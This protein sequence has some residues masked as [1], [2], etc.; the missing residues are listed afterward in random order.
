MGGGRAALPRARKIRLRLQLQL[1]PK[2]IVRQVWRRFRDRDMTDMFQLDF[3]S[4]K[5]IYEQVTDRLKERIFL[6]MIR[7]DE[8]L[9][10]I[11]ELSKQLTVNPNTVQKAFRELERQGYIYTVS[12]VGSFACAR[13]GVKPDARLIA[14]AKSK[15]EEVIKGLYFLVP[16]RDGVAREIDAIMKDMQKGTDADD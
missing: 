2:A 3:K 12:G 10:S 11:R 6:G 14:E 8:K 1:Q 15:L 5:S 4:R 13:D 9:P 16:D 7:A